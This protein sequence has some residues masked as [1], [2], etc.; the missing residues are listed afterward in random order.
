M[1]EAHPTPKTQRPRTDQTDCYAGAKPPARI[2]CLSCK[3]WFR[4]RREL[5]EHAIV[6]DCEQAAEVYY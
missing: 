6:D 3:Q 5:S 2:K 1:N 4:D